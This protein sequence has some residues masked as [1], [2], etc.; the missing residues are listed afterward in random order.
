VKGPFN[1]HDREKA[2]LTPQ[3]Y[4]DLRGEMGILK[5]DRQ[6]LESVPKGNDVEALTNAMASL[7]VEYDK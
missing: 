6:A 3:F 2:G 1:V 5:P 4:E 7:G